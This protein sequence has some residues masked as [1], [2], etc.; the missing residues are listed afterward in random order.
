V[1]ASLSKLYALLTLYRA[2]ATGELSLDDEITMRA[3]D[4]WAYGAGVLYRYPVGTTMTLRE[5][6]EF[7]IKESDNTA[8]VMLNRYLGEKVT[9]GEARET[10]Q[11]VF[12]AAY[13]PVVEKDSSYKSRRVRA[14]TCGKPSSGIRLLPPTGTDVACPESN[15]EVLDAASLVS[16]ARVIREA[17]CRFGHSASCGRGCG[18]EGPR[19]SYADAV[20]GAYPG[21]CMRTSDNPLSRPWVNSA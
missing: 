12:L 21:P 5:C 8:E 17:V 4:V 13:R 20:R 11:D 15:L 6:A 1:T 10:I 3:S 14:L 16:S 19:P 9:E 7:L 2:A 18:H